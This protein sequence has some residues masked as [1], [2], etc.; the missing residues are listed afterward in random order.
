[1]GSAWVVCMVSDT[2]WVVKAADW[3]EYGLVHCCAA[4]RAVRGAGQLQAGVPV[5]AAGLG[6][7]GR[8]CHPVTGGAD[9]PARGA[10]ARACQL[11]ARSLVHNFIG[12]LQITLANEGSLPL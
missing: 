7:G 10:A 4:G 5:P 12:G 11:L 3:V 2:P 6:A 9:C 8:G 1:M